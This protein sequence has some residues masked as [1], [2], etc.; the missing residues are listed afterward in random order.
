MPLNPPIACHAHVAAEAPVANEWALFG[1]DGDGDANHVL[2]QQTLL[3][4]DGGGF[5]A[6]AT[7]L[8]GAVEVYNASATEGVYFT[9]NAALAEG[10]AA[11]WYVPPGESRVRELYGA[12]KGSTYPGPRVWVHGAAGSPTVHVAVALVR[13]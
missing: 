13:P 3:T 2:T 7:D 4:E 11:G 1:L 10:G 6:Q 8:I 9:N 12:S 5:D